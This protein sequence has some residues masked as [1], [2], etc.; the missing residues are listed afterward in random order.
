MF[1]AR[2]CHFDQGS[3]GAPQPTASQNPDLHIYIFREILVVPDPDCFVPCFSAR[4][5]M[6]WV[7][8]CITFLGIMWQSLLS[9]AFISLDTMG[10]GKIHFM[11]CL[12]P[13][14]T[15]V[16]RRLTW[17][18]NLIKAVYLIKHTDEQ[19]LTHASGGA[20]CSVYVTFGWVCVTKCLF[21][22]PSGHAPFGQ[23]QESRP[24]GRSNFLSLCSQSDLSD[25]LWACKEW[26]EVRVGPSQRSRFLV[27][28]K[29][30]GASGDEN[31]RACHA[32]R[33]ALSN[34]INN[35]RTD[36]HC[37]SFAWI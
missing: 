27:L 31:D 24:L 10:T 14:F 23:H 12:E 8:L 2:S 18:R 21:K 15:S 26:R 34:K 20:P 11:S 19:G 16:R 35:D 37:Y 17:S 5:V 33:R 30:S 4:V 1:D 6:L 9:S 7:R 25:L 29:R 3:L 32:M 22:D 36:G 28:T 13:V